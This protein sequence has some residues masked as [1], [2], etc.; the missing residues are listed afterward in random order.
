[1]TAEIK[2]LKPIAAKE[3]VLVCGLP[4][5]AYIGKLSVDYLVQQLKAEQVGEIYSKY[6]PPYVIIKEDGLVDLLRNDCT[7]TKLKA[8]RKKQLSFCQATRRLFHLKG[9]TK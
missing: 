9:N 2:I 7:A 6:F 8:N 3:L 5:I 1:M 4:G